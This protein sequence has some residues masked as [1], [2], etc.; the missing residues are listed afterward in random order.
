MCYLLFGLKEV[1]V[2]RGATEE[3]L[4]AK[5]GVDGQLQ[6]FELKLLIVKKKTLECKYGVGA[7]P[8]EI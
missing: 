1:E 4:Y 8:R 6:S 5:S 3:V 2:A 7:K